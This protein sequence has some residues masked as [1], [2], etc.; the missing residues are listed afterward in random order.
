MFPAA[1]VTVTEAVL[2]VPLLV[3]AWIVG[4]V[5]STPVNETAPHT[6]AV[7]GERVTVTVSLPGVGFTPAQISIR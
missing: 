5:W 6:L 4:V 7:P 3:V 2:P 1:L